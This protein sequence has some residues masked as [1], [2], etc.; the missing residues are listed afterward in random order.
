M[1]FPTDLRTAPATLDQLD[2][3]RFTV[4]GLLVE[5]HAGVRAACDPQLAAGGMSASTFEVLL[6]LARSPGRRMQMTELALQT[7][8][9]N[10]GLTR[11]VDRL[12]EKGYATREQ[13]VDDRR[14]F[15]A[16]LTDAGLDALLA[17]VPGHLEVVSALITEVLEPDELAVFTRALRKI[18]QVAKP[19]ADPEHGPLS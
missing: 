19:G 8:L 2:D 9:S 4:M 17:R 15:H 3:E 7:T 10:S 18:R 16:V 12:M 11:V 13:D 6:R 1:T 14:V 5:A